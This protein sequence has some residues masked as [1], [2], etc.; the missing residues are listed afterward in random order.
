[1][2]RV[3]GLAVTLVLLAVSTASAITEP[4]G[5]LVAGSEETVL[6]LHDLPPGYQVGVDSGC[7]PLGPPEG[8]R[9]RG[10]LQRRYLDWLLKYWPE[11]CFYEYEQIFEVP[12]PSAPPQIEAGT[13]NTP[14]E[15]AADSGLGMFA[16]L[17]RRSEQ[18]GGR[19]T[20]PIAPSGVQALLIRSR[21]ELVAGEIHQPATFLLWRYGKLISFV[22]AA[23]MSPRGNDAAALRFAQIQ[24]ERLEHPTP[25]T[26]AERDDTEVWLDDPGLNF[27]IYW[28]G[29]RFDPG[30]GFPTTELSEAFTGW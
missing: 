17:I 5:K 16:E 26:E 1:M 24:Q 21:N 9:Y 22:E 28:V 29:R 19:T 4:T 25:Y 11:G 30:E 12:G 23:G 10:R 8:D 20:V 27:P 13:L 3:L 18:A 7:G 15:A 14:E 2:A 6:R